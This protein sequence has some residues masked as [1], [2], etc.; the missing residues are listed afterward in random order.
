MKKWIQQLKITF[1]EKG[2]CDNC[3][4]FDTNIKLNWKP[5]EN[6]YDELE[7]LLVVVGTGQ[8]L[9]LAVEN[10]EKIVKGLQLERYTQKQLNGGN[11]GFK[12]SIV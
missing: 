7:V 10:I 11:R 1:D 12:V 6:R 2:V 3:R 4:Y 5:Q 8:N 9:N